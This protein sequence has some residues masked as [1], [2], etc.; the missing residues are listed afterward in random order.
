MQQNEETPLLEVTVQLGT[1]PET[2]IQSLDRGLVILEAVGLSRNAVSLSD[3]TELLG[4]DRS[5]A[6][7]LAKTLK[8]RGFLA[9]PTGKTNYVLGPCIWRLAR[10]Y[11]W[12]NML[13]KICHEPMQ[14]LHVRPARR[15]ILP[16]GRAHTP[17]SS[18]T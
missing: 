13:V 10:Q 17:C 8:R 18:I 1:G 15:R 16:F 3:L 6:F 4:I 7:R 12:S 2:A 11:D 5:S 14:G 9:S